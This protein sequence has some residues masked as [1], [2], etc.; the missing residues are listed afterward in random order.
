MAN[1]LTTSLGRKP[2][3]SEKELKAM[4]MGRIQNMMEFS[5]FSRLVGNLSL[6]SSSLICLHVVYGFRPILCDKRYTA[7]YCEKCLYS[8]NG[9]QT[10]DTIP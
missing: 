5:N 10:H 6:N 9:T 1:I 3:F 2:T 8:N 4:R 7:I